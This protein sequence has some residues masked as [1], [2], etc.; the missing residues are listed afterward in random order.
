MGG[1][2]SDWWVWIGELGRGWVSMGGFSG[3]FSWVGS[4]VGGFGG[5]W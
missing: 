4:A 3:R 1:A 2:G 5:R